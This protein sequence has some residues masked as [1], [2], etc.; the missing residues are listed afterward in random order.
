M[1]DEPQLMTMEKV[2]AIFSVKPG[3]ITRWIAE[4]KFPE[5]IRQGHRLLWKNETIK[6]HLDSLG[7]KTENK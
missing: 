1:L 5:P 4:G 7:P 6:A 3:T 2:A